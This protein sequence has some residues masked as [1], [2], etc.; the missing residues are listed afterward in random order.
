MKK[1]GGEAQ[2]DAGKDSELIDNK[3]AED[4][5]EE[6]FLNENDDMKDNDEGEQEEQENIDDVSS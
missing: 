2:E 6:T 3:S 5:Y 1:D 4:E